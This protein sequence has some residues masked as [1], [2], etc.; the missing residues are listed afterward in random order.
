MGGRGHLWFDKA[1]QHTTTVLEAG[2]GRCHFHFA[3]KGPQL[4]VGPFGRRG[5]RWEGGVMRGAM[6]GSGGVCPGRG[7]GPGGLVGW[8][9]GLVWLAPRPCS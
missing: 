8:R 1:L 3:P 6:G 5:V 7:G 4:T 2:Q 9:G